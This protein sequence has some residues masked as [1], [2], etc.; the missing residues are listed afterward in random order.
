DPFLGTDRRPTYD[1]AAELYAAAVTLHEIAS[2]ELPVWSEDGTD[3]RFAG[4][5]TLASELFDA[6]VRDPLTAFSRK[7]LHRD[8]DKRH[9]SAGAMRKAWRQTVADV[10]AERPATTSH[11][12]TGDPQEERD[13]AA[14]AATLDTALAAAGLSLRA[15]AV[16]QRLRADTVGELLEVPI[17]EL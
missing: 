8:A 9:P 12:S 16:A 6:A 13:A 15:V 7:A 17:R 2:R 4:E 10:D 1:I 11:N 5:V 14:E 3:P